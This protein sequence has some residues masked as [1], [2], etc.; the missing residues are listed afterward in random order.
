MRDKA[1][2]NTLFTTAPVVAR[3]GKSRIDTCLSF[4]GNYKPTGASS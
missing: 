3:K 4:S 1:L 2:M